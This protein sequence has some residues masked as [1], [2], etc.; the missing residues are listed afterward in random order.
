MTY[1]FTSDL[2]LGHLGIL[3]HQPNRLNVFE[4][5]EEMDAQLIDSINQTVGPDDILYHLG[6]FCWSASKAGHYRQRIKVKQLHMIRGNHDSS[7]LR[8]HCSTFQDM[9]CKKF[10]GQKVHML[11]YPM[12]SWDA[13]HHGGIHL[14]GHC[15]GTMEA[16]L[17][18]MFPGRKAMDVG[19]DN[20]HSLIGEWRPISF[21]EVIAHLKVSV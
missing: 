14:Y 1:Y 6:D 18:A 20:I 12:V 7:S 19:V 13:L 2:H 16:Q 21:D 3:L 10:N 4:C 15:H 5:I 8:Q 17:E 9:L 11:H